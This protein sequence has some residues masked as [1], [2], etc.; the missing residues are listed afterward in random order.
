VSY[1]HWSLFEV[2]DEELHSFSR[3]V[4]FDKANFATYSV[5][6]LRLYLSI[7]SEAD[8]VA[9]LLC[10]RV[11]ATLP[12]RPNMDHYR[13]FLSPK[14]PN[15]STVR[16][17]IRPM[18]YEITPW[19]TWQENKNPDWWDKHQ[20]V[21]HQRHQFFSDANLR[22][23]LQAAAGLLVFLVY[24]HQPELWTLKITPVLE[25]FDIEGIGRVVGFIADYQLKDFGNRET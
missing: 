12:D 9:K 6:L 23:V 20:L 3:H 1:P 10:L 11:G 5:T 16:V 7:C 8:V 21:K 22:N 17:T 2:I 19:Q 25:V 18:A 14:Y 15:L 13:K 4:E 24:S